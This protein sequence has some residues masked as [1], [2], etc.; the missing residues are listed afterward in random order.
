MP[1]HKSA[2]KR[3]RQNEKRRQQNRQHKTHA[4][5]LMKK[6]RATED[7]EEAEALLPEVKSALDRLVSKGIIHK[8]KAAN[9]KSKLEKHVSAL[10]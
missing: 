8:N 6:L 10:E 3:V 9:Y 4:R 2:A 7:R 1:Q 5:S